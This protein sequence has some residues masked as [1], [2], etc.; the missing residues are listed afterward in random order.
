MVAVVATMLGMR[1]AH[2]QGTVNGVVEDSAGAPIMAASILVAFTL[3]GTVI[4]KVFGVTLAAFRVAGGL[5]LLVTAL[6]LLRAKQPGTRTSVEETEEG[7]VK[8]DVAVVPLAMP[9]LA[10]PGAIATD[11]AKGQSWFAERIKQIPVGRAAEPEDI[12]EAILFLGS[13]RNRFVVGQTLMVNGG[14]LMN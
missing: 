13:P 7:R 10:G 1:A 5:L 4:F 6:D 3:F 11:V 9:L 14:L 12:A 8:D 2:A